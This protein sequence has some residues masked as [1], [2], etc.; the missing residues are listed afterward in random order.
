MVHLITAE[1]I[2]Q[3]QDLRKHLLREMCNGDKE[4]F[5]EGKYSLDDLTDEELKNL[6]V[7]DNNGIIYCYIPKVINTQNTLFFLFLLEIQLFRIFNITTS[8]KASH[9]PVC[10]IKKQLIQ[11]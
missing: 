3:Q 11:V 9:D 7:D 2:R 6:I 8:L 1:R 5:S 4:A 10:N